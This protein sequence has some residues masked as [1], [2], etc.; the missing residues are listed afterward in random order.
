MILTSFLTG[1]LVPFL[2][3]LYFKLFDAYIHPRWSW[4]IALSLT[5]GVQSAISSLI[6]DFVS[7][8]APYASQISSLVILLAF[9]YM[10]LKLFV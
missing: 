5:I 1:F 3:L 10:D 2:I 7:Y 6:N 9:I 8:H 4:M